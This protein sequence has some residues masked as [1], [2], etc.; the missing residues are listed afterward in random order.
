[1]GS[2]A[3]PEK[4][5]GR[6]AKF[7]LLGASISLSLLAGE[8]AARVFLPAPLPWLYPQLRFKELP[9]IGFGLIP[10]ERA[11]T[12]DKEVLINSRG[13]RGDLIPYARTP[14]RPRLLLLGDSIVFGY[15]VDQ[16]DGIAERLAQILRADGIAAEV[17]NA[18]VPAY[19]IDEEMI[20]L[21]Q[22]GVRYQ[23]DY[24]ILGFCWNDINDNEGVRVSSEGWLVSRSGAEGSGFARFLET[25]FGYRI[26]NVLKQSRMAYAAMVGLREAKGEFSPD[27]HS[28]FR[29][30]V[31][32]G[33]NTIPIE[34]GWARVAQRIRRLKQLSEERRFQ[35][36]VAA[37]PVPVALETRFPA[38]SYPAR[39]R[40][41][42]LREGVPFLDLEASFRRAM[43]KEDSLFIPY[44]AD[45]PDSAGHELAARSIRN[46]LAKNESLVPSA[47]GR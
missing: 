11:Y 1:M 23:P 27:E 3:S 34:R 15:G 32:E 40:D 35:A 20:F 26:R 43:K 12:A 8:T 21:E 25:A 4:L 2:L 19:G 44:D 6:K 22:E 37:F 46:Y 31:L 7:L 17:V 41:I 38:S 39:L 33:K 9:G 13:L 18:G 30:D 16:K 14:G 45:H 29:K 28:L 47:V 36:L 5:S 42:A 10:G 24:V